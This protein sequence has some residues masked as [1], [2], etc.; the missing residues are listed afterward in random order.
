MHDPVQWTSDCL[1]TFTDIVLVCTPLGKRNWDNSISCQLDSVDPFVL[2][3][4]KLL[5]H[6]NLPG[7]SKNQRFHVVYFDDD[8]SVCVPYQVL[9]LMDCYKLPE[10][11]GR[12]FK[13]LTSKPY[14][15]KDSNLSSLQK[16][17]NTIQTSKNQQNICRR[18]VTQPETV[19][20]AQY[21]ILRQNHQKVME[22]TGIYLSND[23]PPFDS[24]SS[25]GSTSYCIHHSVSSCEGSQCSCHELSS[26]MSQPV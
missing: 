9:K 22:N 17:T 20:M 24:G 26:L 23:C 16:L 8:P 12:F 13:Q 14:I 18:E 1:G 7:I 3:I 10:L 15:N 25:G 4:T 11:F 6:A 21:S 5:K 2:S 19:P